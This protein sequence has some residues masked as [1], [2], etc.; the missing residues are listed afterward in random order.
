MRRRLFLM[1]ALAVLVAGLVGSPPGAA[2]A[3]TLRADPGTS[4]RGVATSVTLTLPPQVAAVEG[5][6]L[7][8]GSSVELVGVAPLGRGVGLR[9]APFRSGA[10]FGAYDLRPSRGA[11][12]LALVLAPETAGRL[13]VRVVVD[14]AATRA[15]RRIGV[16]L[17]AVASLRVGR[18]D[19]VLPAPAAPSGPR[20]TSV[21]A[22]PRELVADG[23]FNGR[24]LAAARLEW[25]EAREARRPCG[26]AAAAGDANGDGCAD[27]VD[28][29]VTAAAT[30]SK[31]AY[32]APARVRSPGTRRRRD[33]G[34]RT[35]TVR[36]T[37]DTPDIVP[38]DGVCADAGGGCTLRAAITEAD[39]LRG[40]DRIAFDLPG[41]PPVAI[42]LTGKLPII[43]SRA[44][45]LLIDGYTQPGATPSTAAAGSNAVPGV[46]LIGN[47][48]AAREAV[49]RIT[50]GGNTVRGLAVGNA[51]RSFILDGTGATGNRIVGNWIGFTRDGGAPPTFARWG[52]LLTT[53]ANGNVIGGSDP[54][55]RN[56]IGNVFKGIDLYG[57]GTDGNAIRGNL[58]CIA[59]AGGVAA[60]NIGVD[61]GFGPKG[62]VVGGDDPAERNVI[63]PTYLEGIE[64]AHGWD[65]ALPWGTDTSTTWQVNE[66]RVVGNWIGFRADGTYDPGYRS[67]QEFSRKDNGNGINAYDG[68]NDSLIAGNWV[69]SV[70]DGI[71]LQAPN[72]QRNVVRGNTIGVSP[73]GEAAPL[74]GWGI[75]VRWNTRFHVVANNVI[76]HADQG[77]IGLLRTTNTGA[78]VGPAANIVISRNIV[79]D[80]SGIAIDLFGER[81][82]D[83]SDEG[84][85]DVGANTLLNAPGITLV[86]TGLVTGTA[87]ADATVEVY[88]AT[89]AEGQN[90]LPIEFLGEA[91]AAADG[92]W[93]VAVVGLDHGDRVA[94]LQISPDGNT[95]ELSPNAAVPP[96]PPPA[97][98]ASDDFERTVRRGWGADDLGGRWSVAGRGFRVAR[99]VG[100]V[101][102]PAGKAREAL[103]AIGEGMSDVSVTGRAA[104]ARLPVR[105]RAFVSVLA[106]ASGPD[107]YRAT[108]SILPKG[109]VAVGLSVVVDG[110]ESPL[111]PRV[112][113]DLRVG[114]GSYLAFRLEAVGPELRFRAWDPA[115]DEP[116]SWLLVATDTTFATGQAAGV[117]MATGPT[118]RNGPS[119]FLVDAFR[120][121]EAS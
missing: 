16:G 90:G 18:A 99:G 96:P 34:L 72:A 81:G 66:S 61:V 89:R 27:I 49:I 73:A 4:L 6:V 44:G 88:R 24:D 102:V 21:A 118:V 71:Q 77:G 83:P 57:P 64:L 15:G 26:A 109:R 55:D 85:G 121:S 23:R 110:V 41:T 54:A 74:T 98:L 94:A 84:D 17:D 111:A 52:I 32:V 75:V 117:R 36:S 11:V 7:F 46:A 107:G 87:V 59:P 58:L 2:A 105:G 53:G 33:D 38:G 86:D 119:R 5:R 76:R 13:S 116:A 95:S 78:D 112:L 114:R 37:A 113:T 35:F 39:W 97:V 103:R 100:Q 25:L 47:G 1:P 108:V 14:A 20:P 48:D 43:T 40:D 19:R 65:P 101:M 93:Q 120:V 50:S 106:R 12:R 63:G 91:L 56:V 92:T 69:A 8:A 82:P 68:V 115:V 67:G 45:T 31:T 80:S 42:Q 51:W 10:W 22:A 62:T 70:Y 79:T 9:P 104:V 29:Q 28:V 3:A 60:C 30:G